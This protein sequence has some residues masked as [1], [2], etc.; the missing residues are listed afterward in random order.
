MYG[1]AG[2][3]LVEN[4]ASGTQFYTV[5]VYLPSDFTSP[6]CSN[7]TACNNPWGTFQ[8]LHGANVYSAPPVYSLGAADTYY[9]HL[10]SGDLDIY[11][12]YGAHRI[13]YPLGSLQR[14]KWVDFVWKIKYAKTATGTVDVWR[15][16]EGETNFTQVL[17]LANLPTLQYKTSVNGGAILDSYWRTGHYTSPETFTRVL[18]LDSQTRGNNFDDVV[19]AAFPEETISPTPACIPSCTGKTCGDDECGGS[20]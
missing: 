2:T 14:G 4:E 3:H 8:Q 10:T 7:L 18:Y 1:S 5:S 15:R 16:I 17:T 20:C 9:I 11:D 13:R 19:S 12:K 6:T